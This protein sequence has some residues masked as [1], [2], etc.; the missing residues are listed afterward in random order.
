MH[1]VYH[2]QSQN[3]M[4]WLSHSK[5]GFNSAA[6]FN[7]TILHCN[8]SLSSPCYHGSWSLV[9]L[10]GWRV[11]IQRWRSLKHRRQLQQLQ[12]SIYFTVQRRPRPANIITA[13]ITS[14]TA[15][16]RRRRRVWMMWTV[17]AD[18]TQRVTRTLTPATDTAAVMTPTHLTTTT[19][20]GITRH[21][22]LSWLPV[23]DYTVHIARTC[24]VHSVQYKVYR[25][26]LSI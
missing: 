11:M 8:P 4:S 3:Q 20:P 15:T 9:Q 25:S 19:C 1:M 23:L 2:S 26:S 24:T 16:A 7:C 17:Q 5:Q 13:V 22:S 14:V 18:H 10:G 6:C 12:R 21:H